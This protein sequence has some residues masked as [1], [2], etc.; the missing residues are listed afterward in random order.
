[1]EEKE[2][3]RVEGYRKC[4]KDNNKKGRGKSRIRGKEDEEE[5]EER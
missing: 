1:M 2:R 4:N 3:G 5:N